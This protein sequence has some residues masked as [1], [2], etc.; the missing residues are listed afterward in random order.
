[1]TNHS[2]AIPPE[3]SQACDYIDDVANLGVLKLRQLLHLNPLSALFL[4]FSFISVAYEW[5]LEAWDN[6]R[7]LSATFSRTPY[8]FARPHVRQ[9][10]R[11][12][13]MN[14]GS[15]RCTG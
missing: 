1:M 3:K 12:D 5:V 2:G 15:I 6:L 8:T 7:L 10:E 13:S 4:P 11:E 14:P 9:I